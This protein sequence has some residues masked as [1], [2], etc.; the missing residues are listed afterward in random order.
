MK[1]YVPPPTWTAPPK[2]IPSESFYGEASTAPIHEA[3]GR[4]LSTWEHMESGLIKLFQLL[5]ETKSFAAC[6]AYGTLDSAFSRQL[7]LT[8]AAE[9]FFVSRD[10]DDFS[11]VKTLIKIYNDALKYRNRVAHGMAVQP[12]SFGYFLCPPSYASRRRVTP[13][14]TERW[15][16]GADY[17][18]RVNEIDHIRLRFEQLLAA[19]MSL[20]LFLNDKYKILGN[21]EFHP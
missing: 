8:Y 16:F 5:C 7:A 9:E 1:A 19:A 21:G 12:H 10:K 14:P 15:G 11:K 17:F 13:Y 6:R 2:I 20:V 3:V 18:Y 4:A